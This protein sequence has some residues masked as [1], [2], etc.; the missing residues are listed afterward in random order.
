LAG[1]MFPHMISER[2]LSPTTEF[3]G[4]VAAIITTLCWVPQM[5]KVI[6]TQDTRSLSLTMY[7]MLAVGILLWLTYGILIHSWPIIASNIVTMGMIMV[8]LGM[9]LR[10]G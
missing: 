2:I 5:V 7:L 9:K 3:I 10:H 8:I 1:T 4:F 6:R